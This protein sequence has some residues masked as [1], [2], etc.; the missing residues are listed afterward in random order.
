MTE[1]VDATD[2]RDVAHDQ[3][4]VVVAGLF[5]DL[6]DRRLPT[7]AVTACDDDVGAGLGDPEGALE[8]NATGSTGDDRRAGAR[9]GHEPLSDCGA[10][11]ADRERA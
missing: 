6:I 9:A 10:C 7:L 1:R 2:R 8:T 5:D 4:D 11:S 3:L